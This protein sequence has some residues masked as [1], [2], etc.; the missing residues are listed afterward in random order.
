MHA[1]LVSL[2]LATSLLLASGGQAA[3]TSP[4]RSGDPPDDRQRMLQ[5]LVASDVPPTTQVEAGAEMR[6]NAEAAGDDARQSLA[7]EHGHSH[8]A[9]G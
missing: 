4:A 7:Q 3:P 5:L 9:G 1:R 6:A 8:I 2:A